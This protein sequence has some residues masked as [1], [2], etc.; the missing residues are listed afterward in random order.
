MMTY[1]DGL[2]RGDR[3]GRHAQ[4]G[5]GHARTRPDVEGISRRR[6]EGTEKSKLHFGNCYN[7][8][9]KMRHESCVYR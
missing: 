7:P 1:Q 8:M 9:C 2:R 6:H 4:A 5:G 3:G